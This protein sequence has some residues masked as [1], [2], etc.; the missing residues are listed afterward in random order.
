MTARPGERSELDAL[1]RRLRGYLR[2]AAFGGVLLTR[3]EIALLVVAL[4]G[5][6]PLAALAQLGDAVPNPEP[7]GG[8]SVRS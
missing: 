2:Q 7:E 5:Q 3:K 4:D 8:G 6:E 1:L